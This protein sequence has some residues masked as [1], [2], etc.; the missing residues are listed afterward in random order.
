MQTLSL[1]ILVLNKNWSPIATTTVRRALTLM[2]A[3]AANAVCPL[4]Y[5]V[6]NFE[7][8]CEQPATDIAVETVRQ[9]IRVPE[10]VVLYQYGGHPKKL[11]NFSRK[12]LC[13]RDGYRCAYCGNSHKDADLT[14]DHI[15]PTSRG[16]RTEWTNCVLACY[17]CNQKKA[18]RTPEEAKMPLRTKPARPKWTPH[19]MVPSDRRPQSWDKFLSRV[20]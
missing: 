20:D 18:D 19:G 16:G 4:T 3:D 10:V 11:V 14:I 8:W 12:N 7:S 6:F 5:E 13:M 15:V 17:S 1:P 2:F 9:R